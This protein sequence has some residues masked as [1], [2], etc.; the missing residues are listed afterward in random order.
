MGD[1]P[2]WHFGIGKMMIIQKNGVEL[3]GPVSGKPRC[4]MVKSWMILAIQMEMT[5]RLGY[6]LW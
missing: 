6:N 5:A 3:L 4:A 1:I 2:I